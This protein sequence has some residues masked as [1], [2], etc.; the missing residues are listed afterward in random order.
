MPDI[1]TPFRKKV[2]SSSQP[3]KPLTVGELKKGVSGIRSD[4]IP[5]LE[6]LGLEKRQIDQRSVLQF[7][8]GE[9][10][11][12]DRLTEYIWTKK[13]IATYKETRNGLIGGD[14]S[15]KFSPWL[16]NGCLSPRTVYAEIKKFENSIQSND[17]TYWLVF[18]LLWRDFF[19]FLSIKVGNSLFFP[20]GPRA[21]EKVWST[22]VRRFNLWRDGK[23]GHPFVDAN[24]RELEQSG[25]MSNRGRQNVASFLTKDMGIDWRL[26]AE[27]FESELIDYDVSSNWYVN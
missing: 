25:W 7:K 8:G 10:A 4:A 1:F 6:E 23:T 22:D 15:S 12:L 13:L 18:E 19:K 11:A 20:G 21:V 9:T 17:S 26:G 3:R 27:W 14:Y 16:M 5:S 2:E 24:M